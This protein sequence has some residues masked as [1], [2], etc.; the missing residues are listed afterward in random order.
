MLFSHYTD[1]GIVALV[2]M[3]SRSGAGAGVFA[4]FCLSIDNLFPKSI[5]RPIFP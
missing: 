1:L 5:G 3:N 4:P 2:P